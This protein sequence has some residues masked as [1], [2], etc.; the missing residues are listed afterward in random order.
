[1]KACREHVKIFVNGEHAA[2]SAELADHRKQLR[3]RFEEFN[4]EDVEIAEELQRSMNGSAFGRA[5]LSP[6]FDKAVQTFQMRIAEAVA[7]KAG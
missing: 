3:V 2:T 7:G 1:M 4:N 5:Y 6:A